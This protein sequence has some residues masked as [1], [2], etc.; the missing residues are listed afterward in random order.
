MRLTCGVNPLVC[1]LHFVV[2]DFNERPIAHIKFRATPRSPARC[3]ESYPAST[4]FTAGIGDD[5]SPQ[6]HAVQLGG[7]LPCSCKPC[8]T[9]LFL[10]SLLGRSNGYENRQHPENE[11]SECLSHGSPQNT[12]RERSTGYAFWRTQRSRNSRFLLNFVFGDLFLR[13]FTD[14]NKAHCGASEVMLGFRLT[15]TGAATRDCCDFT[16]ARSINSVATS[17]SLTGSSR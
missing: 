4:L 10:W 8:H 15:P 1:S 3:L 5:I 2:P 17:S 9:G 6:F 7:A 14:Q 13:S 11:N 12:A 16:V